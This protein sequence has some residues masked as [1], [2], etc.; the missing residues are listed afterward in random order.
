MPY[1]VIDIDGREVR[2]HEG[3]KDL[4]MITFHADFDENELPSIMD[5]MADRTVVSVRVEDWNTEMSPWKAD[6]VFGDEGFGEGAQGML[7]RLTEE[8]IP[9]LGC[10]RYAIGGYSLAGLFSLWTCYNSDAF[11]GCAAASP[12]VWFPDWD[13]YI[14]GRTFKAEKAYLSLGDKEARTRNPVMSRV[15]DRIVLQHD[16][17]AEQLGEDNVVLEWN[18]GNHFKDVGTRR[19][20]SLEWLNRNL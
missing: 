19:I 12:S 20:R 2:I 3:N 17:L 14:E 1:K 18:Q 16:A 6:P 4:C 7:D 9:E 11:V 10:D 5:S 13:S 8:I 15:A